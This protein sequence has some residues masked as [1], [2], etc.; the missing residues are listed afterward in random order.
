MKLLLEEGKVLNMHMIYIFLNVVFFQC[1]NTLAWTQIG[2]LFKTVKQLI[3]KDHLEK[4]NS[5][6]LSP[7]QW[8][9]IRIV[10]TVVLS[11]L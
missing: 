1:T 10:V 7:S 3:K 8:V 11:F 9:C 4:K 5:F 2:T 6:D